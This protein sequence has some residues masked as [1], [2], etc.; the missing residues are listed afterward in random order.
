ML[1]NIVNYVGLCELLE[2]SSIQV[3]SFINK[4]YFSIIH[5]YARKN[6]ATIGHIIADKQYLIC[7]KKYIFYLM[8]ATYQLI[9]Q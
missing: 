8:H 1:I 9:L 7:D 5:K 3:M 4:N 2:D 6:K